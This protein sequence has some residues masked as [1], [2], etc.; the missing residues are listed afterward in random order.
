[1]DFIECSKNFVCL[2]VLFV[3][4]FLQ[5]LH[6]DFN[7][8]YHQQKLIH[9]HPLKTT[10]TYESH[11]SFLSFSI[12]FYLS[13]FSLSLSSLDSEKLIGCAR[14]SELQRSVTQA[15]SIHLNVSFVRHSSHFLS[16][17]LSLTHTHTHSHKHT[18]THTHTHKLT[19]MLII[20]YSSPSFCK[21]YD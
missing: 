11:P 2:S 13:V 19:Q 20:N 14:L 7:C 1:M 15:S 17:S 16:L 12:S 4:M 8:N 21:Q 18:H 5:S 3:Q 9:S 10:N 6:A